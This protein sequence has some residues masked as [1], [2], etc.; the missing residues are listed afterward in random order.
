MAL[1][2]RAWSP[3]A[4]EAAAGIPA[5]QV[6]RALADPGGVSPLLAR[7]V[8]AAYDA[9]WD[10][11]PPQ[12]TP[13]ERQASDAARELAQASGWAP[14]AA[15]DDDQIDQPRGRPVPGWR[16]A[17]QYHRAADLAEDVAFLRE[18]GYRQA[19][20]AVLAMRLG[21]R[22]ATLERALIRHAHRTRDAALQ[23]E[24]DRERRA[25]REPEAG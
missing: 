1:A 11:E 12:R 6:D 24:A 9:L 2:S 17:S 4:I 16:R 25:D 3:A 19:P 8:A 23:V 14:P 10:K 18:T 20:P 7:Q 21:V 5:A 13:G 15:W 22:R